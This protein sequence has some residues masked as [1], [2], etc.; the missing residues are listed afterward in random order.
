[1]TRWKAY[2]TTLSHAHAASSSSAKVAA[3]GAD[4]T[5]YVR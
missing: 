2:S 5:G 4:M 3:D 1:M